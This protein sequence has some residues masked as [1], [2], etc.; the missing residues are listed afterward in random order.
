[1]CTDCLLKDVREIN[2]K[3]EGVKKYMLLTLLPPLLDAAQKNKDVPVLNPEV[4]EHS[5]RTQE[6]SKSIKKLLSDV[7]KN[8]SPSTE[9][10]RRQDA[11]LLRLK[12]EVEI[13][14]DVENF[15]KEGVL[16]F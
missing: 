12:K 15:F 6:A 14:V 11:E 7:L 16:K 3:L 13:L 5:R 8:G 9:E 1:M 4:A 2:S 10:F